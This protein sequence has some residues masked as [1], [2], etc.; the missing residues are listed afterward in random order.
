[1]ESKEIVIWIGFFRSK[2]PWACSG[3]DG[4][5]FASALVLLQI[6]I[7]VFSDVERLNRETIPCSKWSVSAVPTVCDKKCQTFNHTHQDDYESTGDEKIPFLEEQQEVE[8]FHQPSKA[9]EDCELFRI[10]SPKV[11]TCEKRDLAAHQFS[12]RAFPKAGQDMNSSFF[13]PDAFFLQFFPYF[14]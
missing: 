8:I 4:P 14:R 12:R 6:L 7:C 5:R 9:A 10:E 3:G 11:Q 13:Y 1:M 2:P